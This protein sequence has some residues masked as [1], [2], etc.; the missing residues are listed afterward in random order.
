[1]KANLEH[2]K[3]MVK[4]CMSMGNYPQ[5]VKLY[6]KM[7]DLTRNYLYK[8]YIADIFLKGFNN[9]QKSLDLYQQIE[10]YCVDIPEFY[11]GIAD[12]YMII[13]DYYSQVLYLQ[14]ALNL[15]ER[16]INEAQNA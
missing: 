16:N 13:R 14:K 5:A 4:S 6:G 11:Y 12:T 1:M 8:V 7:F 3:K 9:P 10:R 15:I 2:Y